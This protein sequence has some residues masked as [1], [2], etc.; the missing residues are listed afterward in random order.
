MTVRAKFRVTQLQQ[1]TS[2][3]GTGANCEQSSVTL[4]AVAG[5]EN[6]TW[7]K[8]TPSGTLTLSIT[9]PEAM[10]QFKVGE[11]YFLDFTP[12]PAKEADE[13]K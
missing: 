7:S 4:S 1:T 2:N 11:F 13:Q 9:N 3:Y 10:A 12:A 5:D 8:W 6:K